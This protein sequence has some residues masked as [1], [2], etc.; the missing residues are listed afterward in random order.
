MRFEGKEPNYRYSDL[1][2]LCKIIKKAGMDTLHF[3]GWQRNGHDTLY[4]DYDT[5]PLLGTKEDLRQALDEIKAMGCRAIIYINGRL[6]DP[7][8]EFY[9]N[10]GDRSVCLKE[11]GTQY[12]ETYGSSARFRL[13]CPSCREYRSYLA[14]QV[15]KIVSQYG[16]HAM[17]VDQIS[18]NCG[19]FCFDARHGHSTP[20]NNF[21]KGMEEELKEI[22][23]VHKELDPDFFTWAE[24]CHERFGQHCDVEQ[25]HGEEF[26]WQIGESTP[27]QFKYT[28]PNRIVTGISHRIQQLCHA[29]AQGKPFDFPIHSLKDEDFRGLV[30]KFVALRKKLPEYF[31]HGK[32]TDSVGLEAGQGV[33]VFGIEK[34]GG[35]GLLVNLWLPGAELSQK[36]TVL[37]KNPRPKWK[38]RGCH[39]RSMRVSRKS[40]WVEVMLKG[41]VGTLVFEPK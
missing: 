15:T 28:Y 1:P 23:K 14:G 41:P 13:A 19:V 32:F 17:Q 4:P 39:P 10:G 11:D 36:G 9:K 7:N 33:R 37:L 38:C 21:L 29:Y 18:C 34:K 26:T 2:G 31:V 30:K 5:D 25:G 8:S 16:A 35:Q 22:R 24:G 6:V 12:I 20:A 3:G 40:G 27:E